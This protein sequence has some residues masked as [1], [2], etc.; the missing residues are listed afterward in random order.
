MK[1]IQ[2]VLMICFCVQVI[3]ADESVIVMTDLGISAESIAAGGVEGAVESAASVMENP[4]LMGD[5]YSWSVDVFQT[6]LLEEMTFNTLGISKTLSGIPE[7][8]ENSSGEFYETGTYGYELAQYHVGMC[9]KLSDPFTLGVSM[10]FRT[11]QLYNITGSGY[12]MD[13]GIKYKFYKMQFTARVTNIWLSQGYMQYS[14]GTEEFFP[15]G[16][17]FGARISLLGFEPM[18]QYRYSQDDYN[19]DRVGLINAGVKWTPF[20]SGM[21]SL[22]GGYRQTK[23]LDG[24]LDRFSVGLNLNLNIVKFSYA[25]EKLDRDVLDTGNYFSIGIL[26]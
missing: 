20:K 6:T 23:E 24:Y 18:I 5:H 14:N 9:Y 15:F 21:L 11:S 3:Y 25:Y 16:G 4:A 19:N 22:L 12:S 26:L 7:T 2:L 1:L 8:A 17:V 13:V 10:K